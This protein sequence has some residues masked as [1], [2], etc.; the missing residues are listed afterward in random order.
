MPKTIKLSQTKEYEIQ[1]PTEYQDLTGFALVQALNTI[2]NNPK[3]SSLFVPKEQILETLTLKEIDAKSVNSSWCEE[4]ESFLVCE[5]GE[6]ISINGEKFDVHDV[7]SAK[8][9]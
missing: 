1:I 6:P 9:K 3:E 8:A 2:Y 5:T 7:D 4:L